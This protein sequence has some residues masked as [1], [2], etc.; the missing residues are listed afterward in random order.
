M[1]EARLFDRRNVI[2]RNTDETFHQR[3]KAFLD[4]LI[5]GGGERCQRASM[6]GPLKDNRFWR[7]KAE[8]VAVFAGQ[9]ECGLVSLKARVTKKDIGH[10]R[11]PNQGLSQ[12]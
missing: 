1:G 11:E 12:L 6:K 4:F 9:L 5:A 2:E 3:L 8:T 7:G 10:A